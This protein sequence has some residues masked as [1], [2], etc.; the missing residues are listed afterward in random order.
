MDFEGSAIDQVFDTDNNPLLDGLFRNA[1][2]Q[3]N[4][5]SPDTDGP[6]QPELATDEEYGINHV[7]Y[8][9]GDSFDFDEE[10][11]AVSALEEHEN[12]SSSQGK[13]A[14]V[15]VDSLTPA[16]IKDHLDQYCIGQERAKR[17]LA[18][19]AYHHILRMRFITVNDMELD[20]S[21]VLLVGPTGT[22]KT[23]L[24]QS[25]AD[26]LDVPFVIEDANE[27][28]ANGY[29]GSDVENVISRLI[30]AANGNISRAQKGIVFID[31]IDKIARK[32]ESPSITRDVSGEEVQATLLKLMEGHTVHVS[33]SKR[34]HPNAS[35]MAI[36]TK[37]I[38]FICSGAFAGIEKQVKSRNLQK[39]TGI[40]FS[41]SL[42]NRDT[43]TFDYNDLAHNDFIHYGLMPEFVGRLPI[44]AP[45]QAL[46][47]T[48]LRAIFT[49]P[50]NSVFNQY[51]AI[52]GIDFIHL[53]FS[54]TAI[55]LM[56]EACIKQNTGARGLRTVV[57]TVMEDIMFDA[58]DFKGRRFE[59]DEALVLKRLGLNHNVA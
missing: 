20:K 32:S 14:I 50:K 39:G 30:D 15:D 21:N 34:K 56:I 40:G 6:Q 22:G 11:G 33:P 1:L 51:Y 7:P 46:D 42:G 45:L 37:N 36:N 28:T 31:E 16:L 49:E 43:S 24:A 10:E 18:I 57:E 9:I 12:K 38:L 47:K 29:V 4:T 59:V 26:L 41:A 58:P 25:L 52:L 2:A 27:F 8:T 19:A 5:R 17:K 23:L 55:D 35:T 44:I 13:K 48:A 53:T 54:E 3:V